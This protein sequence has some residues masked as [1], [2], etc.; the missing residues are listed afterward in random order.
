[1]QSITTTELARNLSKVLDRIEADGGE[2]VVERRGRPIA[3]L[4]AVPGRRT[5]LD[6]LA[7]LY[8]TLSSEAGA[9]WEAD[10]RSGS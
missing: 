8:Q 10:S 6:V 4:L 1:M 2:I 3:R 5:A 7:D 9:A